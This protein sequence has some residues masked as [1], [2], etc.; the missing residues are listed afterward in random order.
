MYE[1]AQALVNLQNV[2]I[3]IAIL[4]E[5]AAAIPGK[6]ADAQNRLKADGAEH[7]EA[8]KAM[9]AAELEV[10]N[11]E[12]TVAALNEQKKSFQSKTAL[13]KNNDEY[14]AALIQIE[15]CDKQISE[16]ETA[17]LIGMEK[18]EEQRAVVAQKAAKL[19]ESKK[20]V[21]KVCADLAVEERDCRAKIAE[22]S[23]QRA[24]LAA[25]VDDELLSKYKRLRSA[26][27]QKP[28]QPVV[29]SVKNGCCGK[30]HLAVTSQMLTDTKKGQVVICGS[31][32]AILY[33]E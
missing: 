12:K 32:G 13:I 9:Q 10:R 31:C 4:E 8:K 2:D 6:S 28:T 27:R 21:E 14:R 17:V 26:K 18:L 20:N 24:P 19:A 11:A 1:W 29:V 33:Y 3:Q 25:L 7:D 16:A 30:C 5:E 23:A 22:I 15:M